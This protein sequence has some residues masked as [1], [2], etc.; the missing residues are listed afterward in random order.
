MKKILILGHK[1]RIGKKIY[2]YLTR[3]KQL[4]IKCADLKNDNDLKKKIFYTDIIINTVGEHRNKTR[5]KES[6]YLFIKKIVN[7]MM[8]SKK[9]K[10]IIHFSSCSVYE[11]NSSNLISCKTKPNKPES[12]YAKTKLWGDQYIREQSKNKHFYYYIVRIPQVLGKK[13]ENSSLLKLKKISQ[14]N[15]LFLL[16]S[17]NYFYNYIF[18]SDILI[19]IKKLIKLKKNSHNKNIIIAENIQYKKL[20]NIILKISPDKN[21]IYKNIFS[22]YFYLILKILDKFFIKKSKILKVLLNKKIYLSNVDFK[23]KLIK[24]NDIK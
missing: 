16:N 6:N 24:I 20:V 8:L 22:N 15:L 21:F 1:G 12:L 11:N 19:F 5:F 3:D 9:K 18:M 2:K 7:I 10:L 4:E 23:T 17:S 14:F 13:M